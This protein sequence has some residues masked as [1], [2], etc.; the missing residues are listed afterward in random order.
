MYDS[1]KC[2]GVSQK[3]FPRIS[4]HV[5][6]L[7]T[8][9]WM[10]LEVSSVSDIVGL[11]NERNCSLD[12]FHFHIY[13]DTM[14]LVT[15]DAL[16]LSILTTVTRCSHLAVGVCVPVSCAFAAG[17]MFVM[18]KVTV[19]HWIVSA[20]F[21]LTGMTTFLCAGYGFLHGGFYHYRYPLYIFATA[22]VS[23]VGL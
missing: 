22:C 5:P 23:T 11:G 16:A 13:A 4:W 10:N 7:A 12:E 6:Q 2:F 21:T 9:H 14:D 17:M 20:L 19:R 15:P 1:K 8:V 3:A 18:N